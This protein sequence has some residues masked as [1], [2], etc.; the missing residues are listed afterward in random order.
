MSMKMVKGLEEKPYEEWLRSHCLFSLEKRKLRGDLAVLNILIRGSRGSG[1]NLFTLMTSDRTQGNGMKLNQGRQV[2][3]ETV[4]TPVRTLL[5]MS[6][7][8]WALLREQLNHSGADISSVA[9]G[10]PH[11][12]SGQTLKEMGTMKDQH[13]SRLI[14]EDW[15]L[16]E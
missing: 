5:G 10:G 8:H 7:A 12:T 1:T 6:G 9:H 3:K 11:N 13:G 2:G 14:L 15:S 4:Y 16:Q